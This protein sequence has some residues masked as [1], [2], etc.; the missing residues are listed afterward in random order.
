MNFI[1]ASLGSPQDVQPFLGIGG[2]LRARGHAVTA[3]SYDRYEAVAR[4]HGLDFVSAGPWAEVEQLLGATDF[5]HPSSMDRVLKTLMVPPMRRVYQLIAERHVPKETILVASAPTIAARLAQE[6]LGLPHITLHLAPGALRSTE[7]PPR[8]ARADLPGWLAGLLARPT[9]AV[10][11][12]QLDRLVKHDVNA[13]RGELG[14]RAQESVARW[15]ATAKRALGLFPE[16]FAPP[17][18]DWP[19]HTTLTHFP[20]FDT[21]STATLTPEVEAFLAAGEPPIVFTVG[22]Q[23]KGFGW[24]HKASVEACVTLGARGI[25]VSDAPQD[26]PKPLPASVLHVEDV[27]FAALLP[28]ARAFVHHA[29]MGVIAQALRAAVPQLVVPWGFNQF[30]NASRVRRLG[31]AEELDSTGYG[32]RWVADS[33]ERLLSEPTLAQRCREVASQFDGVDPIGVT[34]DALEA[35]GRE[36]ATRA[37]AVTASPT[38]N[39]SG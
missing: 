32:G 29:G 22:A 3:I 12:W 18:L 14:L 6:K 9:Y 31:V 20:L 24:F 10:S 16:W 27:S 5:S 28:K 25:L 37:T 30:D 35:F 7:L 39:V 17:Q 36:A 13:F 26:I 2:A 15:M 21:P 34:C 38:T 19:R 4:V 11:D 33:L 23:A 8:F 1:I